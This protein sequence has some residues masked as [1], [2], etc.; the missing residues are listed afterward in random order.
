VHDAERTVVLSNSLG[1]TCEIWDRQVPALEGRARVVRYDHRGHGKPPVPPGPYTIAELGQDVVSLLDS[2]GVERASFCGLSLGGM[3]GMWLA[4]HAPDRIDR[5][6]L[7]CTSARLPRDPW[8]ERARLVRAEGTS[9]V[10]DAVVGRWFTPGFA[11]REQ[12]LVARMRA[13]I[14]ATPAEGYAAC[15]DAIAAMDLRDDLANI[16]APTLVLGA[17]HD[18]AIPPE[19]S[20]AVAAAIPGARLVVIPGAAHLPI[21]EQHELCTRHILEHLEGAPDDR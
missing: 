15:C 12:E 8:V 18:S 17:A 11:A 14:A 10:A 7:I 19:H 3:V 9:A 20:A 16:R 1:T 4:A 21:V 13:M 6:V 5:L 2:L